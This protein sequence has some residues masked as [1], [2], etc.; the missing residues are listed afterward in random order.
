MPLP[1]KLDSVEVSVESLNWPAA[2][3]RLRSIYWEGLY[4]YIIGYWFIIEYWFIIG[5]WFI[6]R[7]CCCGIM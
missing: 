1:L 7:L 2:T 4:W 5:Y 6:I 3:C